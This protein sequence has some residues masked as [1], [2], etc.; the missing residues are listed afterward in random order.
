[1]SILFIPVNKEIILILRPSDIFLMLSLVA[2]ISSVKVP[3]NIFYAYIITFA[4]LF[5]STV[6]GI[7][8]TNRI[9]LTNIVY[10][11]KIIV[12]IIPFIILYNLKIDYNKYYKLHKYLFIVHLILVIWVYVYILLVITGVIIGLW[13]PSYPFSS[14]YLISDSHLYSSAL[15]IGLICLVLY[16]K[17]FL[18]ISDPA[19]YIIIVLSIFSILMTGSRTGVLIIVIAFIINSIIFNKK[20]NKISFRY[21]KAVLLA[22]TLGI[23]IIFTGMYNYYTDSALIMRG[24]DFNLTS[25]GSSISRF[26]KMR[27]SFDQ[28]SSTFYLFGVGILASKIFW[29]DSIIANIN[30][31]FGVIGLLSVL[32]IVGILYIKINNKL[33]FIEKK[34]VLNILTLYIISN[35]ITEYVFVTRSILPVSVFISLIYL[36]DFKRNRLMT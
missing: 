29:Y 17:R 1:M 14:T 30:A 28:T 34:I 31:Y 11:Y 8:S 24:F 3:R 5:I 10:V 18:S 27:I 4:L 6:I 35:L 22:V 23:V 20:L 9:L 13:R 33:P 12:P 19:Y 7:L 32:L 36:K 16:W 15:A 2:I 26:E 25:D 21:S